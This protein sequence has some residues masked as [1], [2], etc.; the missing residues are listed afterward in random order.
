MRT[1][2]GR[3]IAG[4]AALFVIGC[5]TVHAQ[6]S[7]RYKGNGYVYYGAAAPMS[8]SGA[9]NYPAGIGGGGEFFLIRGL[10]AGADFGYF[11]NPGYRD[12]NFQLF[13]ASLG[14]HFKDRRSFHRIDPFIEGG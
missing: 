8:D 6:E 1:P 7:F 3:R 11:T 2:S 9:I 14:Y 13:L 10:A 12:V 4:F 5:A